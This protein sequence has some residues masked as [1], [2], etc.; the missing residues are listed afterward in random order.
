[1]NDDD[2]AV[3]KAQESVRRV[4]TAAGPARLG[5]LDSSTG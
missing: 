1:M 3:Q 5:V 4:L 2:D